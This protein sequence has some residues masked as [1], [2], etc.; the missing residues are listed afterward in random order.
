MSLRGKILFL[1]L[2]LAIAP[3]LA[4][5]GS[6]YV[7]S[8]QALRGLMEGRVATMAG[9]AAQDLSS[10]YRRTA[11]QLERLTLE[12]PFRVLLE[13]PPGSARSDAVLDAAEGRLDELWPFLSPDVA[14]FAI[15]RSD[16]D[17]LRRTGDGASGG[18]PVCPESEVPS[19]VSIGRD[20][21]D[22]EGEAIGR[23]VA[24]VEARSLLRPEVLSPPFGGEGALSILERDTGRTVA[25][26][27]CTRALDARRLLA[28]A[29]DDQ[30]NPLSVAESG[31]RFTYREG[32]S[33]R[34]GSF[35]RLTTP[36][37]TVVMTAGTDN[38]LGPFRELQNGYALFVALVAV[39]TALAF[40][41]LINQ[42]MRSLEDLGEAADR[43]GEGELDPWLPPPSQDEVGRLSYAIG[44]MAER[45]RQMVRQ[46]D[47]SSRMAVVGELASYLAHEIRNPLSS[48]KLN[49]QS[50]S[51][52]ANRG[53]LTTDASHEIDICL[54]EVGRL[55]R[56]VSSVLKL[57]N[58]RP[59]QVSEG[60]VH[61]LLDETLE[62][63]RPEL[64]SVGVQAQLSL[65]TPDSRVKG[66]LG[67]LKGVFLNLLL[68][69]A[70]AMPGGGEVRV[71]TEQG[72]GPDPT[73]VV[74]VSDD[75][76]GVVA[77][78]RDR[79]FEPFFTT[80]ADGSGI[81]LSLAAKAVEDHGGRLRLLPPAGLDQGAS[82][83]V[84]LP[85]SANR[86]S[87]APN[88]GSLPAPSREAGLRAGEPATMPR[89]S[90]TAVPPH[91]AS[92]DPSADTSVPTTMTEAPLGPHGSSGNE[93]T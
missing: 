23:A 47:R 76:P 40:S 90:G 41:L 58:V 88:P 36:P 92:E 53:T 6:A 66:D 38:F 85:L 13:T 9:Y 45:I 71:R 27:G 87:T 3:L 77:E 8:Q 64:D 24:T 62:L 91:A 30:G 5:A 93:G 16:G 10:A 51:R 31:S 46:V 18:S 79:I 82:F 69:A 56:V 7:Q 86:R 67:Q 17:L 75:G 60:S 37:W 72:T 26:I 81:G 52:D 21:L 57:G 33:E 80:K 70:D 48:I 63:V 15:R 32:T 39:S 1:F 73:I 65:N 44:R 68:N 54:R 14:S 42:V 78:L 4:V 19:T 74:T 20:I 22:A 61:D 34:L 2:L 83:A 11:N 35:V 50:L 49:L 59:G 89:T 12:D 29:R 55:E 28:E 43:I 84:E 25:L